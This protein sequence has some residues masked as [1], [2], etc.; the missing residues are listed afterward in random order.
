MASL[1]NCGRVWWCEAFSFIKPA[2]NYLN[3][4]HTFCSIR[5]TPTRMAGSQ[6]Q[7]ITQLLATHRLACTLLSNHTRKSAVCRPTALQEQRAVGKPRSAA[8]STGAP[9][10]HGNDLVSNSFFTEMN[11]GS[12]F[13]IL[14]RENEDAGFAIK[15]THN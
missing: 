4:F 1:I 3:G 14:T 13:R 2:N 11:H 7:G 10:L 8:H 15:K 5:D 6:G 12:S 9:F